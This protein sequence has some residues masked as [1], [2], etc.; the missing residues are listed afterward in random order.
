MT[1]LIPNQSAPELTMPQIGADPFSLSAEKP[2]WMTM[3]VFYRGLHCPICKGWLQSLEA[4][5]PD[6]A[7]RGI[8]VLAA[9]MDHV[10]R[11]EKTHAEWGIA[12]IRL[13]YDMSED[14]ARSFG[15]YIS[16]KREGSDEP[17]RFSEPGLFL[18]RA[19]GTLYAAAVQ[20][21]PFTRPDF[22]ELLGALDFVKDKDYPARGALT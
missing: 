9:S 4:K 5:L 17:D 15:L 13:G 18:V 7:E 3:L 19:D 6:F 11:A 8:G 1:H 16:G 21:M 12:D 10:E 2:D 22:G 14:Q 20:S